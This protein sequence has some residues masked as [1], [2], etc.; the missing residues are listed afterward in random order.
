MNLR[1]LFLLFIIFQYTAHGQSSQLDLAKRTVIEQAQEL[2]LDAAAIPSYKL[3]DMYRST[4][5]VSTHIFLWQT[6]DDTPIYNG[7]ITIGVKDNKVYNLKSNAVRDLK[8][9]IGNS[10]LAVPV[11]KAIQLAGEQ[12]GFPNNEEFTR[13][14]VRGEKEFVYAA[15]SFASNQIPIYLCYAKNAD[16]RYDLA[17]NIDLDVPGSDYW[18]VRI[19]AKTGK[20]ISKNNYTLYCSFHHGTVHHGAN[21]NHGADAHTTEAGAGV[22]DFIMDAQYRVYPF[23]AESPKHGNHEVVTAP[24]DKQA[25]PF[26]WHD[27]DGKEGPEYTITRGNNVS[28]YLDKDADNTSDGNEVDG[29]D[30]LI[31]DHPHNKNLEPADN[32]SSAQVNLFYANNFMHDFSYRYGFT[33]EAG[34]FQE[35]NYGNGGV[36]GDYVLA[37]AA[38]GSGTNNAN[39]ATPPDGGSGRM[40]M[41]LWG[42][43]EFD[44]LTVNK[45][46]ELKGLYEVRQAQFGKSINDDPV[47]GKLVFVNDGSASPSTACEELKNPDDLNGN[48]ALID[49]GLCEFGSKSLKAQ[50]AGAIAAIICNVPGVN[51]DDG[52]GIFAMAGGADGGSVNIPVIMATYQDCQKIRASIDVGIDVEVTLQLPQVVGPKNLDASFDNGVIAHEYGHGISNRLTGGPAQAGCLT[53]D[54]QMG[55]GW[56]DFFTLV[57]TH[58][59]GDTPEKARGIGTYVSNQEVDGRGIRDFPY[60]TDMTISPKTYDDIKGTSAPH[61]LGEV[62]VAALWDMYWGF[63]DKYGYDPDINNQESGNAKAIHVVMRGMV[64]QGCSPGFVDGRDGLLKADEVM[65]NGENYCL[66][67][68]AFARRGVGYDADQGS[69]SSRNDNK[70]GFLSHPNCL[71]QLFITKTTDATATIGKEYNVSISLTNYKQGEVSN[72]TITDQIPEGTSFVEGSSNL[73]A[74]VS[75]NTIVWETGAMENGATIKVDYKLQAVIDSKSTTYFIDDMESGDDN[76]DFEIKEGTKAFWEI[77]ELVAASGTNAWYIAAP[78]DE[79]TDNILY[80]VDYFEVEGDRPALKFNNYFNTEGG[81][82]GGFIAVQVEG[83]QSWKRMT[84]EHNIRNGFNGILAY[85]TFA[86]PSLASFS[87][88]SDGFVDT[89]L[90]LS[91]YKGKRIRIQFRFGTDAKDTVDGIT[92]WA[93]DDVEII[94]LK[95]FSAEACATTDESDKVC[96]TSLTIVESQGAVN[97]NNTIADDFNMELF[98]NPTN[99]FVNIRVQAPATEQATVSIMDIQGRVLLEHSVQ[100]QQGKDLM[101][102]KVDGLNQGIYFVQ[103]NGMKHTSIKRLVIR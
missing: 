60:S 31:F 74:T 94:D 40:Q 7:I 42:A 19:D 71:D 99:G 8:K 75:G 20:I 64:E 36:G 6:I 33:E 90:D 5:G 13:L 41:F 85:G 80:L 52:S 34:N 77:S 58:L 54:E 91:E 57:T 38:D 25:S 2:G 78:G 18:S 101:R 86:I 17:W 22:E 65:Y 61:P 100:L 14:S 46:E 55:E 97:T 9:K 69:S 102:L 92:G 23:P 62:W 83:E 29:T 44:L 82:D 45:P 48:I 21:C 63:I 72:V 15:T 68:N 70:E 49:R 88:N 39:F 79:E 16:G 53:N 32:E 43:S 95:E 87:G 59:P 27:T 96:A 28:A 73:P 81:S 98:P 11:E 84:T 66:I 103:L 93:I 26:G 1:L 12:L 24:H 67:Y 76:W 35:N 89:Y 10:T 4:D 3:S 30:A 37:E 51:G 56:S 50:N 47:S